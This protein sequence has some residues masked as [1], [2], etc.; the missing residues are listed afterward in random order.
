MLL[1]RGLEHAAATA[2]A[3]P[4]LDRL[5]RRAASVAD[6]QGGRR[7]ILLRHASHRHQIDSPVCRMSDKATADLA[8]HDR[9]YK[10]GDSVA[11]PKAP[12]SRDTADA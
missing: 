9:D 12:T 3:Q 8:L 2:A 7:A 6:E 1:L 10:S 11:N 5:I 4:G